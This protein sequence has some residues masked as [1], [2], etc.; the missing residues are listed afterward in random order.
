MNHNRFLIVYCVCRSIVGN[1]FDQKMSVNFPT[2][3][4]IV[5]IVLMRK[6][7]RN[8][9]YKE[10]INIRKA[11]TVRK[12]NFPELTAKAEAAF[13]KKISSKKFPNCD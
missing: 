8:H 5:Y 12:D 3:D 10:I 9:V 1:V 11:G 7:K 2:S 4:N 13:L 6:N